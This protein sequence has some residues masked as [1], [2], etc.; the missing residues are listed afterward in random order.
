MLTEPYVFVLVL[1]PVAVGWS[2]YSWPCVIVSWWCCICWIWH[3]GCPTADIDWFEWAFCT[4]WLPGF[5]HFEVLPKCLKRHRPISFGGFSCEF[6]VVIQ[7]VYVMEKLIFVLLF[8]ND[9]S[10]INISF[11]RLGGCGAVSKASFSTLSMKI[12]AIIGLS[13]LAIAAPSICW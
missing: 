7:W 1:P 6:D 5:H 12:L 9:K 10:V 8:L 4:L 2:K 13:G 11:H 3:G